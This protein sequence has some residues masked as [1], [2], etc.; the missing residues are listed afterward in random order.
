MEEIH[1][2][3]AQFI[4]SEPRRFSRAVPF[5]TNSRAMGFPLSSDSSSARATSFDLSQKSLQ[6]STR[7]NQFSCEK[8]G[9]DQLLIFQ[10]KWNCF[11]SFFRSHAACITIYHTDRI[12]MK[13]L[14]G[15]TPTRLYRLN[16]GSIQDSLGFF[17]QINMDQSQNIEPGPRE[18]PVS[19]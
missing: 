13:P 4:C 9:K 3:S 10:K 17:W 7:T 11:F 1:K 2:K 18:P 5:F 6:N 12:W 14:L 16:I 8:N 19:L 15:V